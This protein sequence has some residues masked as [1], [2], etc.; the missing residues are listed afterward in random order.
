[1][2]MALFTCWVK[3]AADEEILFASPPYCAVMLCETT[4]SVFMDKVATPVLSVAVPS[5]VLPSRNVTMPVGVP[6]AGATG[7]TVAVNVTIWPDTLGLALL[8]NVVAVFALFTTCVRPVE[9]DGA[10]T[11]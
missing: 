1:M 10:L 5:R 6:V 8:V 11:V 4:P 2:V 7:V 9:V 3:A